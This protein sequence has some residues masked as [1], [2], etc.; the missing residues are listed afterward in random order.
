MSTAL[1]LNVRFKLTHFQ[2]RKLAVIGAGQ[3][4]TGIAIVANRIAKLDVCLV[5]TSE[6]GLQ[7]SR[8]FTGM[9]NG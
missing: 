2:A 5:D 9:R 3:M 6:A 4:G 8:Q 1:A 7:R